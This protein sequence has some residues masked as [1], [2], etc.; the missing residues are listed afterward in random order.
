[1]STSSIVQVSVPVETQSKECKRTVFLRKRK[2]SFSTRVECAPYVVF[3]K[4][5]MESVQFFPIHIH[6]ETDGTALWNITGKKLTIQVNIF[7]SAYTSIHE[8]MSFGPNDGFEGWLAPPEDLLVWDG[9]KEYG[10]D[11]Q[12]VYTYDFGGGA[13][14]GGGEGVE[15]SVGIQF[16][17]SHTP[18]TWVDFSRRNKVSNDGQWRQ[19]LMLESSY[20]KGKPHR[21]SAIAKLM[22]SNQIAN[23]CLG[24]RPIN[25]EYTKIEKFRFLIVYRFLG[26]CTSWA[27]E[28][29]LG[30]GDPV[31]DADSIPMLPGEIISGVPSDGGTITE[32]VEPPYVPPSEPTRYVGNENTKEIHDTWHVI[33]ACNYESISQDHKVYLETLKDVE[34]AI[35]KDGYNGCHWCMQEYDTD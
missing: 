19:L 26:G 3:E 22:V 30:D 31:Q 17:V 13:E 33:K 14:I 4:D 21:F 12:N 1:M 7:A 25:H 6:G 32:P 8:S 23:E 34:S 15:G 20:G 5:K 16:S 11:V 24:D 29:I 28:H 27:C 10:S 9:S 2:N 18:N 35:K